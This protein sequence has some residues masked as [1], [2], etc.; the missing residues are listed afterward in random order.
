MRPT[1]VRWLQSHLG[2]WADLAV[3]HW[4]SCAAL[5]ALLACAVAVRQARRAGED[6]VPIITAM[7]CGYLGALIG[8]IAIPLFADLVGQL[9][10]GRALR[11]RWP[12]MVSYAGFATGL[13]AAAWSIRASGGMPLSSFA[14]RLA[15]PCGLA[16]LVGRLGCFLAGCDHGQVS[17]LPWAVRFPAGSPAWAAHL[18]AGLIPAHAPASLPVHPTQL[19]EA[20][21]G[22]LL[23]VAAWRGRSR[24]RR[25]GQIF[26]AV[27]I[28][29][30]LGRCLIE[31]M[32]GDRGRGFVAGISTG[33]LLSIAVLAGAAVLQWRTRRRWRMASAL[34]LIAGLPVVASAEVRFERFELDLFLGS[35]SALNRR[36]GQVPQLR[37][38]SAA[39]T[40]RWSNGLGV[41]LDLDDMS[42]SLGNH[43]AFMVSGSIE[44][45]LTRSLSFGARAGLGATQIDFRESVFADVS[46]T[47]S[48]VHATL[49]LTLGRHWSLSI[50]PVSIDYLYASG[51]GGPIFAY[52]FRIGIGYRSAP[53]HAAAP[54][55][56]GVPAAAPPVTPAAPVPPAAPTPPVA[57]TGPGEPSA[58]DSPRAPQPTRSLH[59]LRSHS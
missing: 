23:A 33:Q 8:G 30:A 20:V 9:W 25:P 46:G 38:L 37:G 4:F 11:L 15:V 10:R 40:L 39:G 53:R 19:Y 34:L 59:L 14:D 58:N 13:L 5:A 57:P 36:S 52:Q 47:G 56:R 16:L 49:D 43:N 1:V 26:G 51:L 28:A 55:P 48:R 42:N 54:A 24:A 44:H 29:Y 32:R 3:P 21:L 35:S 12:G 22:L 27:V 50:W 2:P 41:G 7:L 17:A 45:P 31:T 6:P 18:R